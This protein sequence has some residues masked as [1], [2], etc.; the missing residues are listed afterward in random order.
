MPT[1]SGIFFAARGA[2]PPVLCLHGAGGAH[3]H[4]GHL[5][6][7]LSGVARVV[8]LDL[9]GHGRTTLP[10]PADIAGYG[11]A[12]IALLDALGLE[13]AVLAGH[14]M[15]AAAALEA[16]VA[17]PGR[18][19]G[20]ALIGASAR[21]RVA[22]TIIAGLADDPEQAI[23]QLVATMYPDPSAHLREA[24]AAEYRR[25]PARLRADFL[26]CDGWDIRPRL[27]AIA[28]PAI[29]ITGAAD[30]MTPPKLAQEL[31][32]LIPG[33]ELALLPAVG[34]VPMLEAP[35]PTCA[36]LRAWLPGTNP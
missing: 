35:A 29:V 11:S 30:A 5:L 4:W 25:D 28:C 17:A 24:A 1:L 26:A 8:A 14:S 13:R 18:V 3:T 33:A 22:P 9:P 32:A 12:A 2:G 6:A 21:L 20:L 15:G 7:G 31:A 27:S 19:A 10:A 23:A 34:H 36:A 16:A